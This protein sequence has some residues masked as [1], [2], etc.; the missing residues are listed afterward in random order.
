MNQS[1]I[2]LLRQVSLQKEAETLKKEKE[3][4]QSRIDKLESTITKLQDKVV[5]Q[6]ITNTQAPTPAPAKSMTLIHIGLLVAGIVIG[7]YVFKMIKK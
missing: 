4:T 7:Y 6:P 3:A 2:D 1:S 5:A